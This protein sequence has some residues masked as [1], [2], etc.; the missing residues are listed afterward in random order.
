MIVPACSLSVMA[1]QRVAC[2]SSWRASVHP[3][4]R[5]NSKAMNPDGS[6]RKKKHICHY[7]N[8]SKV[9]GKTSHLRAHIRWHTGERPYICHW[10]YCNKGFT[11][12][13]ELQRH[14][15]THTGEKR[16]VCSKCGKCFMRS[17]HLNKHIKTLREKEAGSSNTSENSPALQST[18]CPEFL[19]SDANSTNSGVLND[20]LLG[21]AETNQAMTFASQAV[22]SAIPSSLSTTG[23]LLQEHAGSFSQDESVVNCLLS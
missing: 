10:V 6:P 5:T 23:L 22:T 11:R 2:Q 19:T 3:V 8:C 14:L 17:N 13:D 21:V 12:S 16:F 15:C 18:D 1:G 7:L 4:S 20:D 9:Y